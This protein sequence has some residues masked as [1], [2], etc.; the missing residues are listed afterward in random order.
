MST[1]KAPG[2]AIVNLGCGR[3][4]K[5]CELRPKRHPSVEMKRR[6]VGSRRR[7]EN[8]IIMYAR[9]RT[10]SVGTVIPAAREAVPSSELNYCKASLQ[11]MS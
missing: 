3:C 4:E 9:S 2:S 8:N 6:T 5:Q 7:F 1:D 11:M 10:E